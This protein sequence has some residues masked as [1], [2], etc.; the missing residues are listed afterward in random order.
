MACHLETMTAAER[1]VLKWRA[2]GQDLDLNPARGLRAVDHAR[3]ALHAIVTIAALPVIV[4]E[5]VMRAAAAAEEEAAA[6]GVGAAA[7]VVSA[8]RLG[9]EVVGEASDLGVRDPLG[10]VE[11]ETEMRNGRWLRSLLMSPL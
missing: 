1:S 8:A 3:E 11:A 7:I 2:R 5:T 9:R 10:V 6:D 4:T